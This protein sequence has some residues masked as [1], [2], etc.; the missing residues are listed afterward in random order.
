M[1]E[2]AEAWF[3]RWPDLARW[4]LK[5]F[6]DLRLPAEVSA[7]AE[8]SGRFVVRSEM[9]FRGEHLR[10]EVRYPAEYPELPPLVF[11]EPGTLSRHQHP[12]GGNFCLLE[13]PLDDWPAGSWGAADLVVD[14]LAAL[15]ADSERGPEAVRAGEAPMPEPYT[16]YYDQPFGAVVLVPGNLASPAGG[17]GV[18]SLRPLDPGGAR[19]VLESL[20]RARGDPRV[21]DVFPWALPVG[22]RW[23]RVDVP[24]PGPDGGAVAAWVRRSLPGFLHAPVPK[25]LAKNAR[26]PAPDVEVVGLVFPEEGPGVAEVRDGWLFVVV[27][28]G[29]RPFLAHAQVVS[30]QERSR[31]VPGLLGLASKRAVIVGAGALGGPIAL[32]L[33]KAGLGC[34]AVV[35][36]DR[37]EANNGVRHVLGIE[38]SGLGKAEAVSIACRRANP[39]CELQSADILFGQT[40]WDGPSTAERLRELLEGADILIE[41]TGSHQLQ[42]FTARAAAE[43]ALPFVSCWLTNGLWGA[44]VVRIVSGR[45]CCFV[46]FARAEAEG[47]LPRAE[48]GPDEVVVAQ[49]C[50]HPTVP[51]AGFDASE[52]AT[53]AT[54]LAVQ[55]ML[56]GEGYPDSPWDYLAMSFRRL[57]GDLGFPRIATLPLVPTPGC[58]R[59]NPSAG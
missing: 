23:R 33:A 39:F 21:V 43:S 45:T 32:E 17:E 26:V 51:G 20:D 19:W 25:K 56:G 1:P 47:E 50:S 22:G 49:G 11:S 59:C 57:A 15:L 35:D 58:E 42:R 37:Y 14:R 5:R 7:A 40:E 24:P 44:Q 13:R 38:Y 46:C 18:F 48:A 2:P 41:T 52:A 27:P 54:R 4:E 28:K 55:T 3:E 10:I 29:E 31:R 16:A 6:A 12:F 53:V 34:L 8:A 36:H 9:M 30:P